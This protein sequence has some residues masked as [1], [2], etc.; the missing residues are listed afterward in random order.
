MG[1]VFQAF[2]ERLERAV[3]VKVLHPELSHD[4]GL[5][6][7]F[8]REATASSRLE[9]SGIV[10]IYD[11]GQ[12][13]H[14][15]LFLVMEWL[16]GM[17]LAATIEAQ[18]PG[19]VVQ[20]VRLLAQAG[21]AL[22]CAHR[23]GLLHRD[24]KPAN[25]FIEQTGDGWQTR[26]LDFG[27]AK[28][29]RGES[30]LTLTGG[31]VGT[32]MY[33]APE[34]LLFATTDWRCDLYAL[35]ASGYEALTGRLPR[36]MDSGV[37]WRESDVHA[38]GATSLRRYRPELSAE[39]DQAFLA[40]LAWDPEQ[41]PATAV[42]WVGTLIGALSSCSSIGAEWQIEPANESTQSVPPLRLSARELPSAAAVS[43]KSP[44]ERGESVGLSPVRV[45]AVDDDGETLDILCEQL[46]R[47]GFEVVACSAAEDALELVER[48]AFDVV[49]SDVHLHG[50]S[51]VELCALL[52]EVNPGLPVIVI[53]AFGD[54]RTQLQA[55]AAGACDFIHKPVE[56]AALCAALKR[57]AGSRPSG[58]AG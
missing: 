44:T 32:P 31:L 58:Q 12:T 24:I 22:D 11:Y 15:E 5:R 33:M 16:R 52:G 9:D 50:M 47:E 3:A 20:V 17:D 26:L 19:S 27:V 53:T 6:T 1:C 38:T 10:R 40:A 34:Q 23:A 45:L 25:I 39:F 29:L 21:R 51:G 48:Q 7:R 8:D 46:G 37:S 56:M 13:A 57:A 42:G 4:A 49:L 2:D 18:G 30:A 14:G 35:A 43:S 55:D 41:R 36:T 54:R 28:E